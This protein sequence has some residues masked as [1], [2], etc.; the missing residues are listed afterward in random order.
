LAHATQLAVFDPNN[1]QYDVLIGTGNH[2]YD[3]MT[4]LMIAFAISN[5][6][7]VPQSL[8]Y[9]LTDDNGVIIRDGATGT[10]PVGAIYG[11]NK[12]IAMYPTDTT[13]HFMCGNGSVI[14]QQQTEEYTF[15]LL[16]MPPAQT[17]TVQIIAIRGPQP[18]Q[19]QIDAFSLLGDADKSGAVDGLDSNGVTLH[20]NTVP[21]DANW[22]PRYDF[23]N[24][25]N[26]DGTDAGILAIHYGETIFD[27]LDITPWTIN[28][29]FD[30]VG[31]G[32][33]PFGTELTLD[34]G[35]YQ[36]SALGK[37]IPFDIINNNIIIILVE[38]QTILGRRVTF[39]RQIIQTIYD[40]AEAAGRTRIMEFLKSVAQWELK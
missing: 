14:G 36:L 34:V 40:K 22:D 5:D 21:G 6:G 20:F 9:S 7:T 37:T 30:I 16:V 17:Y 27:Y 13:F 31:K 35:S 8:W 29:S 11:S 25:G 24:S 33:Y 12:T 23:D 1:N 26:I 32:T 4:E 10:E 39:K 38:Y 18:T 28:D 3:P 2:T 19:A 15:T